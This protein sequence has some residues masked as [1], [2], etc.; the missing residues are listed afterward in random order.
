MNMTNSTPDPENKNKASDDRLKKSASLP[1][2]KKNQSDEKKPILPQVVTSQYK[3]KLTEQSVPNSEQSSRIKDNDSA[4][5]Q[6]QPLEPINMAQS[7]NT[8]ASRNAK[9][10]P[11]TD[12][13]KSTSG[14][15]TIKSQSDNPKKIASENKAKNNQQDNVRN[16]QNSTPMTPAKSKG[17]QTSILLS[18]ISLAMVLA[19]GSYLY[20]HITYQNNAQ[21]DV[22]KDQQQAIR[23]LSTQLNELKKNYD[24]LSFTKNTVTQLQQHVTTELN[25]QQK[26]IDTLTLTNE[27]Q[28]K[29][30]AQ[31]KTK[32]SAIMEADS[33][34]DNYWLLTESN[35]FIKQ[36]TRKLNNDHDVATA[37]TLLLSADSNLAELNDPSLNAIRNAINHDLTTLRAI[38]RIDRDGIIIKLQ[39]L[40]Q[41]INTLSMPKPKNLL[42]TDDDVKSDD[43][44]DSISDWRQNLTKSWKSFITGF[45][46]VKQRNVIN[47]SNKPELTPNQ[48]AYLQENIRMQLL[49]ASQAVPI[50]QQDIYNTSLEKA[51][52]WSK[53]YY[54]T[55]DIATQAFITELEKL[56][57]ESIYVSLP[58]ELTSQPMLDKVVR[59]RVRNLLTESSSSNK[60]GD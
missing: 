48:S 50:Q 40:S 43:L 36:A 59:N 23:S 53:E 1:S 2:N 7:S 15:D 25:Q 37:I 10:Q 34:G 18:G 22:I 33:V 32:V 5:Q 3:D 20:Y 19:L 12:L 8:N 4:H 60:L 26:T 49:I 11:T 58:T 21:L 17:N 56:S 51:L 52:A 44:S 31:L 13:T 35:F 14:Q 38:P 54:N 42:S 41:Q 57:K 9:T 27:E 47:D 28:A 6:N 16:N 46:T 24:A 45:I 29:Q 30:F 39:Q 55:Q